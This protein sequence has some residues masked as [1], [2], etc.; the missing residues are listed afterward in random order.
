MSFDSSRFTFDPWQNFSGVV[1]P[2]GRVQLDSDWNEWLAEFN[3]RI[4][5]ETLDVVGRAGVPSSTPDG[6]RIALTTVA[7]KASVSIGPGRMYV[8]G[9]LAENHGTPVPNPETWTPA[10]DA[11]PASA[12]P[13]WDLSLAELRGAGAVDYNSQPYYPNPAGFPQTGGPYLVF[14]DVWQ[15]E[16][17][18][19][20]DPDLVE[21]A[22]GV[23]TTG[24][25]QTV[26][27]VKWLDA[28]DIA[29]VTCTTDVPAFDT[30][31]LPPGPRLTTGVV[32]SNQTGPCCL[33]SN[34]GFTGLENQLYRVEIHQAGA[35]GTAT[36]KWSRDNA[37]VATG[38]TGIGSGGTVLTVQST[39]KDSVLRFSPNDW[40]EITDDWL[41]LN[42]LP[43]D[44]RQV[45]FVSDSAKTVTLG[46]ALSGSF[47]VDANGQTTPARHTRL[48]R[49][50]QKGQIFKSDGKT[51]WADLTLAGST[52]DIPVP[53]AGTSLILENGITVSFDRIATASLFISGHAWNFA[54]RT[55]DGTVEYLDNA[56]P[57]SI[58][59]HYARLSLVTVPGL[60]T[61][62]RVVFPPLTG[63][64]SGGGCGCCSVTVGDGITSQ[65]DFIDI[66]T[67]IDSLIPGA[68]PLEVC[69]LPGT[70]RPDKTVN[71]VINNL[72]I[73]GC[74][75]ARIQFF[76]SGP[77]VQVTSAGRIVFDT[78]NVTGASTAIAVTSGGDVSIVNC[79][80]TIE[81]PFSTAFAVV[82]QSTGLS[83][84]T[85][86]FFGGGLWVLDGSSQIEV[87]GNVITNCGGPGIAL[88]ALPSGTSPLA[89]A[90]GVNDVEI[91]DNQIVGAVSSAITTVFAPNPD[92]KAPAFGDIENLRIRGN[93]ITQC[94]LGGPTL[95]FSNA[96]TAGILI[97]NC[98]GVS[99]RDNTIANNGNITEAPACGVYAEDVNDLEISRNQIIDNGVG[100]AAKDNLSVVQ[101]G[102]FVG[103]VGQD[104]ASDGLRIRDNRIRMPAGPALQIN[105]T[106][107]MS[108]TN[109]ILE[110]F[111]V[112][113]S[114]LAQ[115]LALN[116]MNIGQPL[117]QGKI[118][119][120]PFQRA[121]AQVTL[122]GAPAAAGTPLRDGRTS[123][124]GNQ[125]TF[126]PDLPP[127]GSIVTY[128]ISSTDDL[129]L[130]HNQFKTLIL[131]PKAISFVDV[132][133]YGTQ[134]LRAIGNRV[135][136]NPGTFTVS[137][138]GAG[139]WNIVNLNQTTHCV[140]AF[141]A[142]PMSGATNQEM[143]PGACEDL[144]RF[145]RI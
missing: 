16:I 67:A 12:Y 83:V 90:S 1:M 143:T 43:G 17:T 70:Y 95:P 123:F 121:A 13:D 133:A 125:V 63:I 45:A 64:Q 73:R 96:A 14:L 98:A 100:S 128:V 86:Q 144:R 119:L 41:E 31:L 61:D 47:P 97:Q 68:A 19:L 127:A 22:V 30:V 80:F 24:R 130:Q 52:G 93:E 84:N 136:E 108:I 8:D 54:A 110:S 69:L 56:P 49:W 131:N 38:V 107:S 81:K 71:V 55:A 62:C 37:S 122:S 48:T 102:I 134:S 74:P 26:W 44:L 66:Q 59:H 124:D 142:N 46:A 42:G 2:Q 15:R 60:P 85:N 6:F 126:V 82:A 91:A 106:G 28:S 94:A 104:S 4:Q 120:N 103:A 18:F 129:S 5:A 92:P 29:G 21:K 112:W 116:I 141:G 139:T 140:A 32:Q 114:T 9:I 51:V 115:G 58:H 138:F 77:A 25:M 40:V 76:G 35:A 99:I 88:G 145:F 132:A 137:L 23:D 39:G 33:T 135:S 34:G 109:N 87:R 78:L 36:F 7:G 20:E 101:A 118:A 53:P 65:G 105:G 113:P 75:Q 111:G 117:E 72:T 10:A 11:L 27:Q 50:D 79:A 3:R 57:R 89:N